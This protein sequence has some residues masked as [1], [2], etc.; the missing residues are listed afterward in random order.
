VMIY[1][2]H[3]GKYVGNYWIAF[4]PYMVP[5]S[6]KVSLSGFLTVRRYFATADDY[7][8]F[9]VGYGTS[10][11]E[12]YRLLTNQSLRLT[13]YSSRI[14][15]NHIFSK[16]W[17]LNVS[18]AYAYEEYFTSLFKSKITFDIAINYLF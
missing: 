10:P 6:S 17:I 18:G 15:Y 7:I 5:D 2:G 12:R 9:Q 11:D 1:T 13:G 8:G 3:V 14:S 4:R 16:R